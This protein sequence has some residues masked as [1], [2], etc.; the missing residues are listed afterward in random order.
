MP[1]GLEGSGNGGAKTVIDLLV[2]RSTNKG[3]IYIMMCDGL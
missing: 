3:F 1:K 2:T